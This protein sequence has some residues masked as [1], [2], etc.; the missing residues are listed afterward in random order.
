M[1]ELFYLHFLL[2]PPQFF[3]SVSFSYGR[4]GCKP[5]AD[6]WHCLHLYPHWI[7][8]LYHHH[9]CWIGHILSLF[10]SSPFLA[11]ISYM[12]SQW[13]LPQRGYST[14]CTH[15]TI[16]SKR[17]GSSVGNCSSYWKCSSTFG[18]LHLSLYV[19][20]WHWWMQKY[21]HSTGFNKKQVSR[22]WLCIFGWSVYAFLSRLVSNQQKISNSLTILKALLVAQIWFF[23]E[24][25]LNRLPQ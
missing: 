22:S 6:T 12:L 16:Y 14:P 20:Y 21:K 24:T 9:L 13:I 25:L 3:F 19:W 18:W 7:S 1:L 17:W 15:G 8:H 11:L 23:L 10:Y 2:L 5:A 4:K